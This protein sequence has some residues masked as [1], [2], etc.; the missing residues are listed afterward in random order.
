M[1]SWKDRDRPC[2]ALGSA[3][4]LVREAADR[5]AVR[6]QHL[7]VVQLLEMALLPVAASFFAVYANGASHLQA[8]VPVRRTPRSRRNIVASSPCRNRR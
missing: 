7:E 1:L 6:R 2:P 8:S 3:V 4:D 5:E